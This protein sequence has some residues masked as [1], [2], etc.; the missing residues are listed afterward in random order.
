[1]A[2]GVEGP[3]GPG[4]PGSTPPNEEE[5]NLGA[6]YL[7][8]SETEEESPELQPL[9]E[10]EIEAMGF[11]EMPALLGDTGRVDGEVLS[12]LPKPI[13]PEKEK[14]DEGNYNAHGEVISIFGPDGKQYLCAWSPEAEADLRARGYLKRDFYVPYSGGEDRF[15]QEFLGNQGD[16]LEESDRIRLQEFAAQLQKIREEEEEIQRR[17]R[18]QG[19]L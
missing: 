14:G 10:K 6:Q 2:D 1:M 9:D 8:G 16:K 5:K 19:K 4:A 13:K 15:L 17:L 3:P 12:E 7:R 11:V 18:E